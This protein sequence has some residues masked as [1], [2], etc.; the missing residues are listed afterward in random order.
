MLLILAQAGDQKLAIAASEILEVVPLVELQRDAE[1]PGALAGVMTYRGQRVP[2]V[3]LT[4]LLSRG[5]CARLLSTRIVVI[6]DG[7]SRPLG[8]VAERVTDARRWSAPELLPCVGEGDGVF[9]GMITLPDDQRALVLDLD[10]LVPADLRE[11]L[12]AAA[13]S[14]KA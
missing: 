8:L 11:R 9:R 14:R 2:V 7:A 6:G 10:R 12:F 13:D 3:D 1:A 4:R 5:E